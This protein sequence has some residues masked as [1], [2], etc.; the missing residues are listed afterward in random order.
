MRGEYSS[1]AATLSHVSGSSPHAWGIQHGGGR[2][3]LQLRFIPTCVGNTR[4]CSFAS[5]HWSVHPHM[6][7][8]YAQPN[9]STFFVTRFIPTCVGN[10]LQLAICRIIHRGSSPHA[11]GI[12]RPPPA[13]RPATRFIPTCVGNT[14]AMMRD[15]SVYS[16]HPHMR[17]EYSGRTPP[18]CSPRGSSPHAWG[19]QPRDGFHLLV[20]RFIPTCVGNTSSSAP[21][22][23]SSSV[24]PHMRGEY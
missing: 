23:W 4:Q 13:Q 3:G 6:R 17:G 14:R 9:L 20:V 2:Q 5:G 21:A 1:V 19:I 12:R 8:E 18:P 11:W 16:V 24:H 15:S 7:G 10:T 22:L